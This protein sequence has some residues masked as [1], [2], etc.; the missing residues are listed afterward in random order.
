MKKKSRKNKRKINSIISIHRI[1]LFFMNTQG[2]SFIAKITRTSDQDQEQNREKGKCDFVEVE[3]I[4]RWIGFSG[5]KVLVVTDVFD[6][7]E[8]EGE[9]LGK[10]D[11]ADDGE[12]DEAG[13]EGFGDGNGSDGLHGLDRHWDAK[14][15]VGGDVV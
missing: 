13:E 11:A 5:G 7:G 3:P 10:L 1:I 15:K 2:D 6:G 14:E 8:G 9:A 4:S 12:G